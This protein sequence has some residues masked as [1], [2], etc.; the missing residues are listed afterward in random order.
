NTSVLTVFDRHAIHLP[1]V[2]IWTSD[3][4]FQQERQLSVGYIRCQHPVTNADGSFGLMPKP[5]YRTVPRVYE[6][7]LPGDIGQGVIV[8]VIISD[9]ISELPIRLGGTMRFNP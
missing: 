2:G 5:G 9:Q 3:L 4:M 8:F 6:S 1:F 7:I